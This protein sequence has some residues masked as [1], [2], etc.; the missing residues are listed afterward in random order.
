MLADAG[1]RSEAVFEALREHPAELV[2]ALGREGKEHVAIDPTQAA[3]VRRDGRK[4]RV[5]ET[6][7]A[8]R[9]RKWLSE[10][11]NGWV[12]KRAGVPTVQHARPD[13]GPGR[14][15][16]RL[17]GAE[18]AENGEDDACISVPKRRLLQ[19]SDRN[20]IKSTASL[21]VPG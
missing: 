21:A 3:A 14:V 12:K 11:P 4:I 17:R 19:R 6:Q 7:S 9:R 8:Y 13:Q 16:T 10:P 15:E 5:T 2:V 1:Y 18:P 20:V